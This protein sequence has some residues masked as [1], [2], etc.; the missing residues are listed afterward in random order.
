MISFTEFLLERRKRYDTFMDAFLDYHKH[1]GGL[2]LE[3][4]E[5]KYRALSHFH[6]NEDKQFDDEE[7]G[8]TRPPGFKGGDF[9]FGNYAL[10][11]LSAIDPSSMYSDYAASQMLQASIEAHLESH[12]ARLQR[13]IKPADTMINK[14]VNQEAQPN[15]EQESYEE[16]M[17]N[18]DDDDRNDGR[19]D[20][21]EKFGGKDIVTNVHMDGEDSL[22]KDAENEGQKNLQE[23]L[24]QNLSQKSQA[25]EYEELPDYE[26]ME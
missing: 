24:D 6:D 17:D 22:N 13:K 21:I 2:D 10:D 8:D 23:N 11:D 5:A 26:T 1:A 7:E 9:D 18:E 4:M 3:S 15:D 14:P 25:N 16:D 20:G 12:L 19:N